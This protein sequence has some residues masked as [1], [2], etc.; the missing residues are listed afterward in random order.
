MLVCWVMALKYDLFFWRGVVMETILALW[1]L[2]RL[3]MHV[4][5][6]RNTILRRV[7]IFVLCVP[8][9]LEYTQEQ[10]VKKNAQLQRSVI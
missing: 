1:I 4:S 5:P 6:L 2:V 10:H 3:M 8:C 7:I 9:V